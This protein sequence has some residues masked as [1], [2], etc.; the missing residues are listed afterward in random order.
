MLNL[1]RPW[2]E[3]GWSAI[4]ESE[5]SGFWFRHGGSVITV[6]QRHYP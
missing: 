6:R 4:T 1:L 5:Y 3:S 2:P